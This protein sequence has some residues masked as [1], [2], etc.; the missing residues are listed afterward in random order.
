MHDGA[1]ASHMAR[2]GQRDEAGCVGAGDG[3]VEGSGQVVEG[4]PGEGGSA[5]SPTRC[6]Q[7][8]G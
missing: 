2:C 1:S 5:S 4:L 6:V 3:T 8:T 7:A